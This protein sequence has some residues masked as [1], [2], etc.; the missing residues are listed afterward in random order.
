MA[1]KAL[2]KSEAQS[3]GNSADR[4]DVYKRPNWYNIDMYGHGVRL[5]FG[6]SE[7]NTKWNGEIRATGGKNGAGIGAGRYGTG[8]YIHFMSC[9]LYTS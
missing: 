4:R 3:R 8:E 5:Y 6:S 9:L 1:Q 7:K 2:R